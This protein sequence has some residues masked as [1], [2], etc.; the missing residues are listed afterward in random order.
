MLPVDCTILPSLYHTKELKPASE[1]VK[2]V[3]LPWQIA[4]GPVKVGLLGDGVIVME[5]VVLSEQVPATVRY[6]T[7]YV[8]LVLAFG[9]TAPVVP[10]MANPEVDL[11]V[12]LFPAEVNDGSTATEEAL[13]TGLGYVKVLALG[14]VNTETVKMAVSL[15]PEALETVL[16][17]T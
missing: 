7:L 3:L 2:V 13:Q 5:E 1:A 11:N 12:P 10:S 15:Q 9:V 16:V 8:P 14:A 17:I 4:L 6:V